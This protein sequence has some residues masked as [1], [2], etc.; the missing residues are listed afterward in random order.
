MDKSFRYYVWGR[1][2]CEFCIGACELLYEHGKLYDFFDHEGDEKF[3]QRM[4]D[5]YNHQ[6]VPIIVENDCNTGSTRFVG[7]YDELK[8]LLKRREND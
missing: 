4:K 3:V 5:F 2:S 7:G 8:K 1:R 6:T